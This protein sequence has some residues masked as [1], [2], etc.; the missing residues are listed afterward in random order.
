[1]RPVMCRLEELYRAVHR[2]L[3]LKGL[4]HP[5]LGMWAERLLRTE[6]PGRDLLPLISENEKS[7]VRVAE[8]A[9]ATSLHAP[10]ID[11]FIEAI[12]AGRFILPEPD[13]DEDR[14]WVS[15]PGWLVAFGELAGLEGLARL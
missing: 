13:R 12:V 8:I 15:S 10:A 9:K 11:A 4:A 3:L 6:A 5:L 2:A 7:A 14:G 1:M